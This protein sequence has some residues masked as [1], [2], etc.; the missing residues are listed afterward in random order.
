MSGDARLGVTSYL[1]VFGALLAL[2][3][4]TLGA[5]TLTIAVT[6][7][8]L[9]GIGI[10]TLKASLVAVYFM[11]L[12]SERGMVFV[13]LGLTAVFG[14]ALFGLTL[15]TEADHV[16]GTRFTSPFDVAEEVR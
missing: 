4:A 13:A 10:A 1:L 7:G 15:W 5:S 2:T 6:A 14:A 12:T 11:H 8:V 16:P 3:A 9:L